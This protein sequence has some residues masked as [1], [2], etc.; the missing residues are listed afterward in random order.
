MSQAGWAAAGGEDRK[1]KGTFREVK[2]H[3]G[4]AGDRAERHAHQDDGKILQCEGDGCKGQWK[5]DMGANGYECGRADDEK[6][7]AGEGIL[8][9][10]R[11]MGEAELRGNSRL[12]RGVLSR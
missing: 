10:S 4:E 6:R 12:H 3:R 5:G 8:E 11:T 7:L 9:R 1:A 2:N